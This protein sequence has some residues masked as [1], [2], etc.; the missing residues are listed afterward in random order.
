M[1]DLPFYKIKIIEDKNYLKEM[2]D[3]FLSID[4]TTD[5][6]IING[7]KITP[8]RKTY[9]YGESYTYSGITKKAVPFDKEV[10]QLALIIEEKLDLP[11][12]YFNA[13]L[14]NLYPDG[15][16]G[17]SYHKDDEKQM[18]RNAV[19][20]SISFG[21][22]RKFN[23]KKD[24]DGQLEKLI[25]Q[26]GEMVVMEPKTQEEWRHSV[27]KQKNISTPRISLTFRKFN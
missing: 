6:Y 12:G 14:C 1:N 7:K 23:L 5:T 25:H 19:I 22:T 27:P 15:E 21:S 9:M 17:L 11:T 8:K 2:L 18:D 10:L 26:E 13:C 24:S 3:Y 20:V 16:A 4:W